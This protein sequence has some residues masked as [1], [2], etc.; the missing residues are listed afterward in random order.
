VQ[1]LEWADQKK[2]GGRRGSVRGGGRYRRIMSCHRVVTER[3][4]GEAEG[5]TKSMSR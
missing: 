1:K 4:G 5:K 2:E 3:G